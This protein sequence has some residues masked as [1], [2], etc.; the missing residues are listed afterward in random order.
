MKLSNIIQ[1]W[2]Q[3]RYLSDSIV[4]EEV[5]TV[6]PALLTISAILIIFVALL[7][8][9]NFAYI[10]ETHMSFGIVEPKQRIPVTQYLQSATISRVLV[11]NGDLVKQGQP[12]I[13]LN[14]NDVLSQIKELKLTEI[15][16]AL[17]A[18][19]WQSFV[20]QGKTNYTKTANQLIK[21]EYSDFPDQNRLQA[22]I[23]NQSQLLALQ[24]QSRT[25]K[26]SSVNAAVYRYQQ[27][28]SQLNTQHKLLENNLDLLNKQLD[29]Y[30]K[31]IESKAISRHDYLKMQQQVNDA[32]S[33]LSVLDSSQAEIQQNLLQSQAQAREVGT[34][35]KEQALAKLTDINNQLSNTRET[36]SQNNN[37]VNALNISAPVNGI[38]KNIIVQVGQNIKSGQVLLEIIPLERQLIVNSNIP[39]RDISRISI[40][41]KVRIKPLSNSAAFMTMPG[42]VQSISNNS[43]TD[44]SGQSYYK[45][46]ISIDVTKLSKLEDKQPLQPGMNVET[47]IATGKQ[48]VLAYLLKPR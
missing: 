45:A 16:L 30:K 12:L 4:L 20:D 15:S 40:G 19:R 46:V 10:Q 5:S 11:N 26:E 44:Q 8:W 34:Q 29:M 42:E 41:D 3:R 25:D 47:Y 33:Q 13:E 24:N 1:T 35:I 37:L 23:S 39:A 38:I 43:Y 31:L 22:M 48:S 36:V 18:I 2:R 32:N 7:V 6:K 9:S 17:S 28:N 27:Q 21:N 14:K